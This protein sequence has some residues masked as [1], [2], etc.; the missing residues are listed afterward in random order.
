VSSN[1]PPGEA[2]VRE[3]NGPA[4]VQTNHHIAERFISN[5]EELREVE[6]GEEESFFNDSGRRTGALNAALAELRAE[7]ALDDLERALGVAP[8]FNK[9][10]CQQ[11]IFCPRTGDVRMWGRVQT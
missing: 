10:T 4:L 6:E 9:Y 8:V 2:A 5:N 3:L 7:C 11:M 1:G